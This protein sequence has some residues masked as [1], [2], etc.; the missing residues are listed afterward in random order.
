MGE[1]YDLI[2]RVK[3]TRINCLVHGESGTGKEVVARAIHYSGVRAGEPFVAI[4]CGAIPE[5]LVESELFGHKK[6]SFTGAVRDKV[7]LLTAADRGTVFL[8]EVAALP[9]PAQ[10]SLLRALQERR[11][12]PVGEVREVGVDVRVIAASNVDLEDAVGRG[13][14]RE[15]L[16]Y[17]LNVVQLTLPPLRD[18]REDIPE[19]VR[20]FVR[21]FAAEYGKDLSGVAPDA[22]E[23]LV[24]WRYPGNV[25]E[26]QNIV[27]RAVALCTGRLIR[28]ADLPD[29]MRAGV[30]PTPAAAVEAF[31]KGGMDLDRLL[32]ETERVWLNAA[33]KE[34][35]GNKTKAA[36][37]L[38]MSFRSLRYRL[39]K[40][41]MDDAE[42]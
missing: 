2:R 32:A 30:L 19:L 42:G 8:D 25:R 3:D 6:G 39:A 12:T 4:N 24:A 1:V 23:A 18:R 10:V 21:R 7:G 20:H 40:Y 15:D 22:L 14:F 36:R 17:R 29:R 13:Q 26:L 11:F 28:V 34:A 37:L 27:E 31:P 16:Y 33:L 9:L 5:N 38:H 35:G 41:G